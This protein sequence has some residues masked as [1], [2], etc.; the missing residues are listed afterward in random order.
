ME[1]GCSHD[2]ALGGYAFDMDVTA[3]ALLVDDILVDDSTSPS[4]GVLRYMPIRGYHDVLVR[5]VHVDII[6]MRV[7]TQAQ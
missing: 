3:Y 7:R 1:L 5:H 4:G 2:R 6:T